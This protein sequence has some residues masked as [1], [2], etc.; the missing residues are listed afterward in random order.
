M[1]LDVED[2]V[3]AGVCAA[4]RSRDDLDGSIEPSATPLKE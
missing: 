4:L 3:D 2:V 1:A